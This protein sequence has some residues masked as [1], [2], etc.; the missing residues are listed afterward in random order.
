MNP[1]TRAFLTMYMLA[2]RDF[3]ARVLTV[4]PQHTP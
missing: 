2:F 1:E 3:I 4:V